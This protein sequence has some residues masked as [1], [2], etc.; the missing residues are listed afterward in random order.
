L[1]VGIMSIPDGLKIKTIRQLRG[2]NQG[3]VAGPVG[4]SRAH[5]SYIENGKA[6]LSD[7]LRAKIEAV[8]GLDLHAPAVDAA[9]AVLASTEADRDAVQ[10]AITALE[11]P[12]GR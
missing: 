10:Q 11:Q 5:L 6:N 8:L 12:N 3:D 9:F 1:S 4:V 7:K 2:F